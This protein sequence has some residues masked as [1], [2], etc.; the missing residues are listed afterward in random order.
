[1]REVDEEVRHRFRID[2]KKLRY[3][4]EFL[5]GLDTGKAK[6]RKAFLG[7][8][9]AIQEQLGALN[10]AATAR[11]LLEGLDLEVPTDGDAKAERRH[12]ARAAKA[13]DKL[14]AAGPFW[15]A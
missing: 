4:V 10:D 14:R 2:V 1:L 12:L 7:A 9:E 5:E 6:P 8:L 15:R 11:I 13:F 3:A